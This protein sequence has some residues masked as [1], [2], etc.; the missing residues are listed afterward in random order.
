MRIKRR[1]TTVLKIASISSIF[2]GPECYLVHLTDRCRFLNCSVRLGC[3]GNR[4]EFTRY[5]WVEEGEGGE[6]RYEFITDLQEAGS[7]GL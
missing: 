3:E 4:F 5:F 1:M 6:V 7:G 2:Y